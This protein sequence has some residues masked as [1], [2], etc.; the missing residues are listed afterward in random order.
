MAILIVSAG[1]SAIG[2]LLF[3]AEFSPALLLGAMVLAFAGIVVAARGLSFGQ[4]RD[5]SKDADGAASILVGRGLC[6]SCV[7][8][9]GN[10]LLLDLFCPA[11][12]TGKTL[13]PPLEGRG[14]PLHRALPLRT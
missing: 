10:A 6:A 1:G 14:F 5:E 3:G 4:D 9:A 12:T 11:L 8:R 13:T 7:R 2:H